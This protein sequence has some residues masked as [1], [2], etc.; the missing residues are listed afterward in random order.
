MHTPKRDEA[1]EG[2]FKQIVLSDGTSEGTWGRQP[3]EIKSNVRKFI[4]LDP[5]KAKYTYKTRQ[6]NVETEL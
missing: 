3:P 5:F 1:T 2:Q 6:I 4:K